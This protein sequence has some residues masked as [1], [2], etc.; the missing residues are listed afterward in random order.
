LKGFDIIKQMEF[1]KAINPSQYSLKIDFYQ[2]AGCDRN[3]NIKQKDSRYIYGYFRVEKTAADLGFFSYPFWF[4][5][6]LGIEFFGRF[7]LIAGE[8]RDV[9]VVTFVGKSKY[10]G[11]KYI[12]IEYLELV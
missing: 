5:R 12:P 11:G 6:F 8:I 10:I 1:V 2:A 3:D 4:D 9:Q 7:Y